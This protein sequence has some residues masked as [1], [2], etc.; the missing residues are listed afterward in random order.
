MDQTQQREELQ[1]IAEEALQIAQSSTDPIKSAKAKELAQN[2]IGQLKGMQPA[3]ASDIGSAILDSAPV[4]GAV[5]GVSAILSSPYEI[6][7]LGATGLEKGAEMLGYGQ[8]DLTPE[9]LV[10]GKAYEY[11]AGEYA[12]KKQEGAFAEF[13]ENLTESAAE[14]APAIAAGPAAYIAAVGIETAR[15]QLADVIRPYGSDS[16]LADMLAFGIDVAPIGI[17]PASGTITPGKLVGGVSSKS[18]TLT[19]T[20]ADDKARIARRVSEQ[21][22]EKLG[23]QNIPQLKESKNMGFQ[24][25]TGQLSGNRKQLALENSLRGSE[26]GG[27]LM[28]LDAA[29]ANLAVK[30]ITNA[31]DLAE[32]PT[33]KGKELQEALAKGYN[34][35]KASI[36][37]KFKKDTSAKFSNMSDDVKFDMTPVITKVDELI[38]DYALPESGVPTEADKV[39][40]A[41][42]RLKNSLLGVE[43]VKVARYVRD[44]KTGIRRQIVEEKNIS[45]GARTLTPKEMQKHLQDIGRMAFTGADPKFVGVDSSY[46]RT[47][48]KQLGA[49]FKTVLN[50]AASTGDLAAKQLQDARTF[51]DKALEDLNKVGDIPFIKWLD[52]SI[53]SL[54]T[55]DII[56]RVKQVGDTDMPHVLAILQKEKPALIPQIQKDLLKDMFESNSKRIKGTGMVQLDTYD[57]QGVMDGLKELQKHEFFASVPQGQKTINQLKALMPTIDRLLS[58]EGLKA[59]MDTSKLTY[60]ARLNSEFQGVIFGTP[61]RYTAQ[62]GERAAETVVTLLSDPRGLA[63]A[64]VTPEMTPIMRKA[65][66]KTKLN[67]EELK[68]LSAFIDAYRSQ[69]IA[70]V[71]REGAERSQENPMLQ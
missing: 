31:Y 43:T 58:Q 16:E 24:L 32:T 60:F 11:F 15:K 39:H 28:D 52:A 71:S 55:P 26:P 40:N 33:L 45:T 8:V 64:A 21:Q 42:I 38:K 12:Y 34:T 59:T 3:T 48:G 66:E 29:N 9:W 69:L 61:G 2:A 36:N 68:T 17:T 5:K 4:T 1:R 67:K 49:E 20:V 44:P 19:P 70:D 57:L 27:V 62:V 35:Y 65:L 22:A 18:S 51:Y 50:T 47:I 37:E 41:L 56:E 53:D 25:T 46:T 63:M 14:V 6:A 10:P 30:Y 7:A 13:L 23:K 54:N